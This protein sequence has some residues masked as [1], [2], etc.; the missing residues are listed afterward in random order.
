MQFTWPPQTELETEMFARVQQA[1]M[2]LGSAR[3]RAQSAAESRYFNL[4]SRFA[5]LVLFERIGSPTAAFCPVRPPM[6]RP[7]R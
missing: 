3:G 4:L 2:E 1:R 7:V 5:E 6:P